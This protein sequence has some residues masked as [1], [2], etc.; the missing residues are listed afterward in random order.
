MAA[1]RRSHAGEEPEHRTESGSLCATISRRCCGPSP[2]ARTGTR[3]GRSAESSHRARQRATPHRSGH[4]GLDL[5]D[6]ED[7]C[8]PSRR[9]CSTR[10]TSSH[11]SRTAALLPFV[12]LA[13]RRSDSQ[14][15]AALVRHGRL[16]QSR[17]GASLLSTGTQRR[18]LN[19]TNAI[20]AR[21][22]SFAVAWWNRCRAERRHRPVA[23]SR[24]DRSRHEVRA[25][26]FGILRLQGRPDDTIPWP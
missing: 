3:C 26:R 8:S 9:W 20:Q 23:H 10:R 17:Q 21:S 12:R 7:P 24:H 2:T 1:R 11:R 25:D 22:C 5:E 13:L 16:R 6:S 19:R 18:G 4:A 15:P 14:R